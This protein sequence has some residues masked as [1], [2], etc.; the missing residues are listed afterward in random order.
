MHLAGDFLWHVIPH[1][2]L[3][4]ISCHLSAVGDRM[5]AWKL[6]LTKACT[7]NINCNLICMS[8]ISSS[9][10]TLVRE[11]LCCIVLHGK[12]VVNCKNDFNDN[13]IS[14][15]CRKTVNNWIN[16]TLK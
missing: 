11:M 8:S 14:F 10:S 16:T 7:M 13:Y 4:L 12:M 9:S 15:I 6:I 1:R 3:F 5:K 2:V